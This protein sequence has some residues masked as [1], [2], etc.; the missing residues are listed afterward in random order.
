MLTFANAAELRLFGDQGVEDGELCFLESY[1]D[2]FVRHSASRPPDDGVNTVHAL[3]GCWRRLNIPHPSWMDQTEWVIDEL[4]ST[5]MA[6][7]ENRGISDTQPLRTAAERQR[8]MGADAKWR[9]STAYHIRYLS[10]CAAEVIEGDL[11]NSNT[12]IYLH[13][14]MTDRAGDMLFS[15]TA[16]TV[17]ALNTATN[18]ANEIVSASIPASW[19]TA[20]PGG[21]SLVA[22]RIRMTS[23]ASIH[24]ISWIVLD[25]GGAAPNA[26][27]RCAEFLT[28]VASFNAA[29]FVAPATNTAVIANGDTFVVED[30]RTITRL[31]IRLRNPIGL[32]TSSRVVL[33]S[34]VPNITEAPYIG[35]YSDGC[36][37]NTAQGSVFAL[38][39]MHQCKLMTISDGS[40]KSVIG[41]YA[42]S[43]VTLANRGTSSTSFTRWTIQGSQVVTLGA[44]NTEG[45]IAFIVGQ[46]GI[47]DTSAPPILFAGIGNRIQSTVLYGSGNTSQILRFMQG[48]RIILTSFSSTPV[49]TTATPHVQLYATTPRTA[50]PALD[51]SVSPPVWTA[52]RDLTFTTMMQTVAAGGFGPIW[53]DPVSGAGW[54]N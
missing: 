46:V 31:S 44:G 15:G 21:T 14:S 50:A 1:R 41:G 53:T 13:G 18:L 9:A 47:F 37:V 29:P 16:T 48:A 8:R 42:P 5:G 23:G 39:N 10:T 24:A 51:E 22:K 3:T 52:L 27:A 19:A 49:V 26:R 33:D 45:G 6:N 20:G 30:L 43:G 38:H 36:Q 2:Y 34:V 25:Q 17:Q 7:D 28:P 40:P 11:E 12:T 54:T 4:N 32:P 35:V